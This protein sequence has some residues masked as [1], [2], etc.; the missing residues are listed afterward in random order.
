MHANL[1]K[2]YAMLFDVAVKNL[3]L[4]RQGHTLS[5]VHHIAT[6]LDGTLSVPV[7]GSRLHDFNASAAVCQGPRPFLHG[8]RQRPEEERGLA[9]A[10]KKSGVLPPLARNSS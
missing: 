8:S 6:P 3:G 9:A 4:L 2:P 10:V 5:S 1:F 7:S